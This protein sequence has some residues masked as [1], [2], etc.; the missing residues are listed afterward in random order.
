M[1]VYDENLINVTYDDSSWFIDSGVSFHVTSRKNFFSSYTP[2]D[3]GM[4]EMNKN[5]TPKVIGIGIVCLKT[6]NKTKLI[7]KNVRHAPNIHLHLIFATVLH[8]DYYFN[9]F[10]G[11]Q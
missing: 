2:G 6:S 1:I 3:F 9:T 5:D 8:D 10:G 4:L 11:A 7:L